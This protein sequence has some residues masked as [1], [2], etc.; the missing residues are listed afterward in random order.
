[1]KKYWLCMLS[2]LRKLFYRSFSF[3]PLSI[4]FH[5][6]P[7]VII[8]TSDLL[9]QPFPPC[10]TVSIHPYTTPP[11]LSLSLTH[12]L[13]HITAVGRQRSCSFFCWLCH[14]CNI[15]SLLNNSLQT[16]PFHQT[17]THACT[18]NNS[19]HVDTCLTYP[20]TLT[21]WH[22]HATPS[23]YTQWKTGCVL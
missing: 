9:V 7:F 1:M 8:Y 6:S 11:A 13:T 19:I 2:L 4:M 10:T 20:Q 18:Q 16:Q 3:F 5:S 17:R 23:I 14:Y 22:Q 12:T 21:G 15:S